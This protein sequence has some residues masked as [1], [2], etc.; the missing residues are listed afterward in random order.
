VR[1]LLAVDTAL[2]VAT[3][4]FV[5]MQATLLARIVAGAFH[6]ASLG[7]LSPD[8]AGLALAF[9]GRGA[10]PIARSSGSAAVT[11]SPAGSPTASGSRLPAR[12]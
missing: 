4:A 7:E 5:V 10:Q 3:V 11:R 9:A 12:P 8:V 1:P 2:G 6:G